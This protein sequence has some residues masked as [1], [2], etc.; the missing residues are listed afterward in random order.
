MKGPARKPL[1]DRFWLRV[2]KSGDCWLWLGARRASGH[3]VVA[4]GGHQGGMLGAHRVAWELT[5]GTVPDGLQVCHRCD[6]PPCVNPA[7]LFL[8]TQGDNMRDM[9]AKGRNAALETVG[10]R[11]GNARL[12]DEQIYAIRQASKDVKTSDLARRYG[13]TTHHIRRIVRGV[14]RKPIQ[15]IR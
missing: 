14:V 2:D 10:E 12:T 13:V 5:N 6:N 4:R 8:G 11:N 3:G 7:H 9:H 15:E 1:G